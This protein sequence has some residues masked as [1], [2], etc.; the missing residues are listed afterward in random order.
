MQGWKEHF[1]TRLGPSLAIVGPV[2]VSGGYSYASWGKVGVL[3]ASWA[4]GRSCSSPVGVFCSAILLLLQPEML[5]KSK[6]KILSGFLQA[7]LAPF[8]VKV[9]LSYG[10][11]GAILGPISA[12]LGPTSAILGLR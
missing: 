8:G 1:G 11:V 3:R 12:I 5:S 4:I 2:K 7:M 9:L 6:T 10:P